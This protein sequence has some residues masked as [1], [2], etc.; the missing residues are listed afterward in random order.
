MTR[1]QLAAALVSETGSITRHLRH[2]SRAEASWETGATSGVSSGRYSE[3]LTVTFRR[4]PYTKVKLEKFKEKSNDC[5]CCFS[6]GK[7]V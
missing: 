3:G 2:R 5:C 1:A 6:L 7:V 4:S